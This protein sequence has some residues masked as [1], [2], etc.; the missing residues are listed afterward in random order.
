MSATREVSRESMAPRAARVRADWI[1]CGNSARSKM[2]IFGFGRPVGMSPRIE[3]LPPD[4]N[5]T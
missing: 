2:G 5:R 1:I 4:K 3:A